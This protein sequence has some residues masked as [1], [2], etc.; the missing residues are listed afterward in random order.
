MSEKMQVFKAKAVGFL[1]KSKKR[2]MGVATAI[3]T[4]AVS[5]VGAFAAEPTA[6][7]TDAVAAITQIQ[8]AVTAEL[9]ITAIAAILS[10]CIGA[11]TVLFLAWWGARKV[12]RVTVN[13]FAK[14]K[15]KI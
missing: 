12:V 8:N 5:A 7:T 10:A 1:Q 13:A 14:G 6:G 4:M 11:A 15:L 2:L 3:S 9:N